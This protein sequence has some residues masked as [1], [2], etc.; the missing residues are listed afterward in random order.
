MTSLRLHTRWLIRVDLPEETF[1][2]VLRTRNCI[3][4]VAE[5]GD[6]VLGYMVYELHT[7]S[8]RLLTLA[9]HPMYRRQ[10]VGRH[11]LATLT[12]KLSSHWRRALVADVSE[13]NLR[14]QRFLA[15]CGLRAT[16]VLRGHFG[17][18][19]GYRFEWR[20][21]EEVCCGV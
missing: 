21:E 1:L 17:D 2:Y 20:V 16:K 9:V 14:A 6:K 12:A 3:G 5:R 19:D 8:L 11:L 13:R 15:A 4:M 7:S 18:W 10:G